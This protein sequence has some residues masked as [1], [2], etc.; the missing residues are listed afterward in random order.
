[1]REE[2]RGKRKKTTD[3][4]RM[5]YTDFSG[6]EVLLRRSRREHGSKKEV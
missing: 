4:T 3:R 1:M 5:R 2:R 6:H